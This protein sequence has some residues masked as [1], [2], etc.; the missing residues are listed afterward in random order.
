[1]NAFLNAALTDANWTDTERKHHFRRLD[2]AVVA[3]AAVGGHKQVREHI[4]P[5]RRN[6]VSEQRLIEKVHKVRVAFQRQRMIDRNR[7]S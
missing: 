7:G 2:I 6:R 1:M 3:S 4:Q 5:L